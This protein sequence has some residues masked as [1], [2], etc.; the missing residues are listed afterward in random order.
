MYACYAYVELKC[1]KIELPTTV[2]L[3]MELNVL[4]AD[5]HKPSLLKDIL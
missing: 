4:F 5:G 2:P 1:L 3:F